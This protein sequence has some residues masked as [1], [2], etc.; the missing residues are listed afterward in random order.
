MMLFRR[1][2]YLQQE[3]PFDQREWWLM[4]SS[5]ALTPENQFRSCPTLDSPSAKCRT[6]G[7]LISSC[8]CSEI[9]CL[10]TQLRAST[11]ERLGF[12]KQEQVEISYS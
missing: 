4:T 10:A 6:V 12:E 2:L 5:S 9:Q 8:I 11:D 3:C 1:C 7:P